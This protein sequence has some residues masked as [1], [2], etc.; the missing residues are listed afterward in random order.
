MKKYS[1][2]FLAIFINFFVSAQVF[3]NTYDTSHVSLN[4]IFKQGTKITETILAPI[5]RQAANISS[6]PYSTAEP[7]LV[8]ISPI[9]E[10][11]EEISGPDLIFKQKIVATN[12]TTISITFDRLNLSKNAELYLY[13]PEGTIITGP[14]TSKEN[15]G[16]NKTNKLWRSNSL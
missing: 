3:V 5:D 7:I 12:A 16:I 2:F 8:D 9:T 11:S 15:I 14:I 6:N 13:N 10:A 1:L 4:G